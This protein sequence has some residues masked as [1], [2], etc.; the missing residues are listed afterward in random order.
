MM[1][2]SERASE[3]SFFASADGDLAYRDMGT[4]DPVVL[5]HS[6]FADHRVFADQLP[7]LARDF[8]VI[9]PDIRGHGFSANASGPFRWADDL[10]GLLRHLDLGPAVLVGLCM[11][12]AVATDTA[13]EHPDLVRAVV[14]S[15]AGTSAFEY[16]DPQL[17]QHQSRAGQLLATG[18][19]TGWLDQFAEG[20]AGPRRTTDQ[21]DPSVL[22]RLRELTAHTLAK[23]TPGEKDW[24]V[25]LTDPWPRVPKLD[26]PVLAIHGALD[27][28]DSLAMAQ[29]FADT[30]PNGHATTIEDAGHYPNMEKPDRFN[31]L[32]TDFLGTL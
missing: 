6:G 25:P 16:A 9:A 24:F 12:A 7:V 26:A 23:H 18:D 14:V 15:G 22:R 17:L 10:A 11:G 29:R 28:P 1:A 13:L 19:I 20:V 32:L 2:A 30:V 3:L 31:E 27:W 5:L 21:V 4:G 8:R